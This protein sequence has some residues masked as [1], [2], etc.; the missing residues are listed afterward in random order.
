[1]KV[2][3]LKHPAKGKFDNV[4]WK[5]VAQHSTLCWDTS[6]GCKKVEDKKQ[7]T[8]KKCLKMINK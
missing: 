5:I 2:V 7:V 4:G 8:C 6:P 1:M 3:H